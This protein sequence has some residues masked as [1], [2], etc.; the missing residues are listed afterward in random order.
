MKSSFHSQKSARSIIDHKLAVSEDEILMKNS[1]FLKTQRA[2]LEQKIQDLSVKIQLKDKEI[3]K[4]KQS[5]SAS[6]LDSDIKSSPDPQRRLSTDVLSK[7][8]FSDYERSRDFT[9]SSNYLAQLK[10]DLQIANNLKDSYEKKYK[11]SLL[12]CSPDNGPGEDLE[13]VFELEEEYEELKKELETQIIVAEESLRERDYLKSEVIPVLERTLH[14]YEQN[15]TEM[16]EEIAELKGEMRL[17]KRS[18]ERVRP[19]YVDDDEMEH[20]AKSLYVEVS[21]R[22]TLVTPSPKIVPKGIKN[23]ASFSSSRPVSRGSMIQ[24]VTRTPRAK[25]YIPSYLRHKKSATNS[26]RKATS[27]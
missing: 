26:A 22:K 5:F 9:N 23:E 18:V 27:P 6:F 17:L 14:L 8:Q 12:I 3:S 2:Q 16:E 15:K 11:D 25:I 10:I 20:H 7:S 13:R 19:S 21:S 24:N 1:K 4:L